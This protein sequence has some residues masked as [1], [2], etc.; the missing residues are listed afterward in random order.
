MK[1]TDREWKEF[2]IGGKE[3]IF[4]LRASY[5]GIDKNKLLNG[6]SPVIPY[7]TRSD[8]NNGVS[9]FV[10]ENQN[11]K[12]KVDYGN[13]ITIGLDTQTV[14]YQSSLFYTGQNIQVLSNCYLNKYNALFIVRLL[15]MQLKKFSWGGNGATLGRLARTKILLPS[16]N[17][18]PDYQFMEDYIKEIMHKKRQEYIDYAKGNLEQNSTEQIIPLHSKKWREFFVVDIFP[19][20]QRGKRLIK[21]KQVSGNVP[22]VSSTAMNNGVDNF[23]Q[24]DS[25]KMRKYQNCLSVANSGSVG[26]SFYEPFEYVA[27]DHVTH[28]KND[29]FN[30]NI[31]LFIAAMTNRWSQKYNFNREINDPRISREKILLPVNNN[32]E[33]DYTYME[34]YV[35]NILMQKYNDYLEYAEK[36]QNI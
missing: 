34:Q 18:F 5:S 16:N 27:S 15:K 22:Y 2:F 6:D 32:D 26:A 29:N 31:Y 35:N 28:L 21:D 12:Y 11:H 24:Y 23:I 3:G 14:F 25:S 17:N 30:K 36:F 20:I 1:L 7:I 4:D 8:I 19:S 13:V 9:L 33:P 10:D